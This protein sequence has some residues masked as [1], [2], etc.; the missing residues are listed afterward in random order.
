[1]FSFEHLWASD[2]EKHGFTT[3]CCLQEVANFDVGTLQQVVCLLR[4][5]R[6]SRLVPHASFEASLAFANVLNPCPA[7]AQ[8]SC[9]VS[10]LACWSALCAATCTSYLKAELPCVI[11]LRQSCRWS[12]RHVQDTLPDFCARKAYH[13]GVTCCAFTATVLPRAWALL[14]TCGPWQASSGQ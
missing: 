9:T 6:C 3:V 12:W 11:I 5:S 7:S 10:R 13:M 1:M 8:L 14:S 4:A 2:S